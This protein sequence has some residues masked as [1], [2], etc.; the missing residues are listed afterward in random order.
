MMM[1]IMMLT[2]LP[3]VMVMKRP[4]SGQAKPRNKAALTLAR[5]QR[6]FSLGVTSQ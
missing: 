2:A 6:I 4:G 1:A 3:S 5:P